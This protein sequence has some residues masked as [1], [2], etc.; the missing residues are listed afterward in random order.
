MKIGAGAEL[1]SSAVQEIKRLETADPKGLRQ[2][3]MSAIGECIKH[4][5]VS[6]RGKVPLL[7]LTHHLSL[8]LAHSSPVFAARE[9]FVKEG[10][11]R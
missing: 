9:N 7:G 8:P 6:I 10:L 1:L 3:A 4:P 11:T 5:D 2:P